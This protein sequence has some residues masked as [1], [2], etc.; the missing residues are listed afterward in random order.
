MFDFS[1][2]VI[3][4]AQQQQ[5]IIE[6][7][8]LLN[9]KFAQFVTLIEQLILFSVAGMPLIILWLIAGGIFCTL[10]FG[11][12][13]IR[14]FKHALDVLLGKY[15][16]LDEVGEVSHFQ[17]LATALSATV[18]V[19]NIAGVAIAIRLGGAGAVFWMTI[20][21]FL[22]MSIKFVECTLGQK[23]RSIRPD[24]STAGGPMYYLSVGLDKQGMPRLG[25]ILGASYALLCLLGSFGGSNMFQANQSYAAAAH[26]LPWL[27]DFNWLYGIFLAFLVGMVIIGGIKRI[28]A[29][30]AR[31]VPLMAGIYLA[32]C[33]WVVVVNLELIPVAI[34]TIIRQAI[35]PEAGYGGVVGVL[36]MGYRRSVFSNAAGVGSAA[37]AHA[38]ART[39]EPVREGI[40]AS[41][42]P[43]IDT[44]IICNLTALVIVI[45]GIYQ[46]NTVISGSQLTVTSF[47]S[48]ISWF[49][50]IIGL[51][52]FLFAFS[53][54]ISC[55]Y[56]GE[57]AWA[58]LLGERSLIIY[59]L[60]FLF[61]IFLGSIFKLGVVLDF[62]DM[63]YLAMTV[64]NLLGCFLMSN[65]VARDLGD[66]MQRLGSGKMDQRIGC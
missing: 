66:Y 20:A 58:Y 59:K 21:G 60:I 30:A 63:M 18:G 57:R 36:I 12:I 49:P 28:S 64:P 23:Y 2:L 7:T 17:A 25:K 43:L 39:Q 62:S 46:E 38:A 51:T 35:T 41:L 3:S 27:A 26:I 53:T 52:V 45:T 42:E 61:C 14:A 1:I 54:L 55:S 6:V 44:I 16:T 13:N 33:L 11:F 15:D 32:T 4:L 24:G 5:L 29:V 31:I 50:Y 22:G 9:V 34:H 8:N 37:I 48:V 40:V 65:Q 10:R 47:A 19:G 56:Y